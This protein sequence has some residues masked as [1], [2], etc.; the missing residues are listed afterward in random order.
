MALHLAAVVRHA[1]AVLN[2]A[3]RA[4]ILALTDVTTHDKAR[5]AR[6]KRCPTLGFLALEEVGP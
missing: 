4:R 6:Q 3:D 1:V 5:F 2:D